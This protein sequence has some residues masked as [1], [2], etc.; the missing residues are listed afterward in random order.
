MRAL[1]LRIKARS[2]AR[3]E[4]TGQCGMNHK[5]P[6]NTNGRCDLEHQ[7]VY[8]MPDQDRRTG[9]WGTA[10]IRVMLK[11]VHLNDDPADFRETNLAAFCQSCRVLLATRPWKG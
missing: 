6:R 8:Q 10:P 5:D 3:C 2:Q 9:E 4:C 11:L 7:R 1:A